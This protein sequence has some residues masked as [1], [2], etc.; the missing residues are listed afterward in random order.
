[1]TTVGP[2]PACGGWAAVVGTPNMKITLQWTFAKTFAAGLLA[3]TPACSSTGSSANADGGDVANATA[4]QASAESMSQGGSSCVSC[5]KSN[6]ASQLSA[7]AT[8]CVDFLNCIC[9][10][11]TFD[12]TIASSGQCQPK[13]QSTACESADN[14]V[15]NC[16]AAACSLPCA[17]TMCAVGKY[18]DGG[19]VVTDAASGG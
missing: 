16:Q 8:G 11:G 7:Q 14:D 6:C 18:E 12:E 3:L 19:C 4:C 10:N 17:S 13:E 1:M 15:T 5:M 9:P 2:R